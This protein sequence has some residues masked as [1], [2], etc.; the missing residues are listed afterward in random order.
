MVHAR[1]PDSGDDAGDLAAGGGPGG[2]GAAD[3]ADA[4]DG[5]GTADAVRADRDWRPVR[6]EIVRESMAIAVATGAYGISFGAVSLAAGLSVWQTMALS[7]LMFT[8]GQ[9]VRA[10]RA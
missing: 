4:L 5:A 8:G 2:A 7:V 9:P 3:T 10:G 6:R 1:P